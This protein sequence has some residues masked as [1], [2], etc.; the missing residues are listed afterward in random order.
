MADSGSVSQSYFKAVFNNHNELCSILSN[1]SLIQYM[2]IKEAVQ[3][4]SVEDDKM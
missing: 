2:A 1:Q 4:S 3:Q